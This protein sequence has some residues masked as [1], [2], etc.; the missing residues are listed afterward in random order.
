[1]IYTGALAAQNFRFNGGL[2]ASASIA[3]G[4]QNQNIKIGLSAVGALRY[5][6]AALEMGGS[7]VLG[8]L[9]KRHTVKAKGLY[10]AYDVFTVLGIGKNDNLLGS[11]FINH[12]PALIFNADAKGTFSGLGFGFQ[13]E[14]LPGDLAHFNT[15]KGKFLMRFA[16]AQHS[17]GITFLNDFRFGKLFYGEGTDFASTGALKVAYTQVLAENEIYSAGVMLELFTPKPDYSRTPNQRLN[18]DD[19][20]KNVWYTVPPFESLFYANLYAF[21]AY[22]NVFYSAVAKAGFNSEK[23][24]AF[25]QNILHD[26]SGLNPRFPWDV[27]AE[28][29]LFVEVEAA[30]LNTIDYED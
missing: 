3:L 13:K 30:L 26:G 9:Y 8:Q 20:R 12:A 15:R 10:H 14:T 6:E 25:V 29:K 17:I 16:N 23:L 7:V 4:N 5:G 21:T 1:M 28:D 27:T 11:T 24:G 2:L 19:G 22:Q 18:S